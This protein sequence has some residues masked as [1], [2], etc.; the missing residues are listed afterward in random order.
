MVKVNDEPKSYEALEELSEIV[1]KVHGNRSIEFGMF[2]VKKGK[3]KGHFEKYGEAVGEVEAGIEIMIEKKWKEKEK[4][5]EIYLTLASFYRRSSQWEQEY[6]ALICAQ[7]MIRQLSANEKNLIRV[8]HMLVA[9]L[10]QRQETER[11][12]S[13]LKRVEALEKQVYGE[14]SVQISKTI[15]KIIRL[16]GE[17]NDTK[18]SK[19][20]EQEYRRIMGIL[21]EERQKVLLEIPHNC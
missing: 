21:G 10:E 14:S 15:K 2:L 11:A 12:I 18:E 3:A 1:K 20:Y 5:A 7:A 13:E 4:I 17:V 6:T 19:K 16:L 8:I 9:N